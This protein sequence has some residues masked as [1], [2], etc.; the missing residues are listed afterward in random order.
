MGALGD[1]IFVDWSMMQAIS[2]GTVNTA[3]SMHVQ[4][5]TDELAYRFTFRVDAQPK[6]DKPLTPFKGSTTTSPFVALA[7]RA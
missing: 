7:T 3:M 4:F 1:L 5:V 6:W 2:K